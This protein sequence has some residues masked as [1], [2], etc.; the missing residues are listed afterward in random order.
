MPSGSRRVIRPLVGA[1]LVLFRKHDV[2]GMSDTHRTRG[3]RERLE[4]PE[5]VRPF[6]SHQH[7]LL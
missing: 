4:V 6:C 5:A 1:S 2:E 3:F 7:F